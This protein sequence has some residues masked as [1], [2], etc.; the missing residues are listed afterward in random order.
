MSNH[1]TV[2]GVNLGTQHLNRVQPQLCT[3]MHWHADY[4]LLEVNQQCQGSGGGGGDI[5]NPIFSTPS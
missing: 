4:L 5:G 2:H 1:I 3:V